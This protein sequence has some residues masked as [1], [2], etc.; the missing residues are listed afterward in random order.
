MK[1][2]RSPRLAILLPAIALLTLLA[3][4]LADAATLAYWRFEG[5]S[6]SFLND[7]SGGN[8]TLS[9]T[10]TSNVG[11]TTL[12]D[13]GSHFSNPIPQTGAANY[14]LANYGTLQSREL[15][16]ADTGNWMG[17]IA[18]SGQFTL[19][20]YVSPRLNLSDNVYILSQY[21]TAG[22]QRSFAFGITA[23]TGELRMLLSDNGTSFTTFVTDGLAL[24]T[25]TDYYVAVSFDFSS[26]LTFYLQD[27]T[28]EGS[29]LSQSFSTTL[30]GVFDST[31]DVSVGGFQAITI[32]RWKGLIDEV[33][34]SDLAMGSSQLLI[35]PE[36]SSIFLLMSGLAGI[37]LL[38]RR[39]HR[40]ND[41]PSRNELDRI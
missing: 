12:A 39:S 41:I 18:A 10:G 33:R 17:A 11:Q 27:L 28:N 16:V 31:A 4:S 36:P 24:A 7:S 15:G 20:A 13:A 1:T 3:S 26:G 35:V 22:N 2:H 29:L 37:G 5:D 14:A 25:D 34:I 30:T 19:E 6:S 32:N 23:G 40:K 21:S 9:Q 8:H 38:R